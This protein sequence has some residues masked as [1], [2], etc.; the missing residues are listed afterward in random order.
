M[1][2]ITISRGSYSHGKEVA[3][4]VA[5]QL[6]YTCISREIMVKA[7]EEFNIPEIKLRGALHDA[8]SIFDRFTYGKERYIAYV[9]SALLDYA[10]KDN[11]V[12]HGLAGHFILR[13]IQHSLNVR[14]T[15]DLDERVRIEMGR[16]KSSREDALKLIRKDDH[17]RREWSQKIFG[18]DTTD[19]S[20]YDLVI[21]IKKMTV[22]DAVD[23][24]LHTIRKDCF[25]TTPQSQKV[26]NDMVLA[27]KVKA[28]L[29]QLIPNATM[30]SAEGI[31]H[32]SAKADIT[33]KATIYDEIR[34]VVMS[35]PG[36][37]DV[38][39]DMHWVGLME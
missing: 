15:A 36:V 4:K 35:V 22:D 11:M 26:V 27:A 9:E 30:T 25:K 12:Y 34:N 39:I 3:E 28:R 32:I 5:Q 7:S 10:Q 24:I 23:L 21:A 14:I 37:K 33:T 8:P 20:L 31:I 2:I 18:V 17:E 19:A 29:V 6:G 1:S 13:G 16:E 38:K